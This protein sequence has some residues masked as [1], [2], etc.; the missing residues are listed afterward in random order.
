[1]VTVFVP[2]ETNSRVSAP[3]PVAVTCPPPPP[4]RLPSDPMLIPEF[5]S[6]VLAFATFKVGVLE[7]LSKPDLTFIASAAVNVVDPDLIPAVKLPL[8]S[9]PELARLAPLFVVPVSV[10]LAMSGVA[11]AV[12]S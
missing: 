1:M 10:I 6:P 5:L 8:T 11:A 7:R 2:P 4:E 9:S 3:N 12:P